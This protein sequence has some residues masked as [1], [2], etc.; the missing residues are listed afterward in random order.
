GTTTSLYYYVLNLQG[1]VIQLVGTDGNIAASYRYDPWGRVI[2]ATGSM[3]ARKV[4]SLL[5]ANE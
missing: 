3:A 5:G 1:D 2:S 4:F